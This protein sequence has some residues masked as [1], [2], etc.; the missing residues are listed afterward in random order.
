M[1]FYSLEFKENVLAKFIAGDF[2][3]I[4]AL[5]DHFHLPQS[6]FHDWKNKLLPVG[7]AINM[8]KNQTHQTNTKLSPNK[9]TEIE[10]KFQTILATASLNEAEFARYCRENQLDPDTVR[11]WK[12]DC[13]EGLVLREHN[14]Q[15]QQQALMEKEKTLRDY[16]K[17]LA[18]KDKAL[19]ETA[20]LLVLSKKASAIWGDE[21]Q[22]D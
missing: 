1:K 2:I 14:N 19:A 6:T 20:A 22:D 7:D 17:E 15:V 4:K 21:V 13:L 3:S 16:K 9:R 10:K 18:R 5:C 11:S 12:H 8:K